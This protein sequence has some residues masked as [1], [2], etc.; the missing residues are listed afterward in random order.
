[1]NFAFPTITLLIAVPAMLLLLLIGGIAYGKYTFFYGRNFFLFLRQISGATDPPPE[2]LADSSAHE[3][4]RVSAWS[5]GPP[6]FFILIL[7]LAQYPGWLLA[8]LFFTPLAGLALMSARLIGNQAGRGEGETKSDPEWENPHY[9]R[10]CLAPFRLSGLKEA[11][12]RYAW[13]ALE[14]GG[15]VLARWILPFLLI[16]GLAAFLAPSAGSV[17]DSTG[18]APIPSGNAA[19]FAN[20]TGI[21]G[22]TYGFIWAGLALV[23]AALYF[24]SRRWPS[25][26]SAIQ[27]SFLVGCLL[28]SL[29]LWISLFADWSHS[30]AG[31]AWLWDN[32][33]N[34]TRGASHGAGGPAWWVAPA[35]T[36]AVFFAWARGGLWSLSEAAREPE[37]R[38]LPGRAL[39]GY[40]APALV[41]WGFFLPFALVFLN[42]INPASLGALTLSQV[43]VSGLIPRL[44]RFLS[45]PEILWG[46]LTGWFLLGVLFFSALAVRPVAG[47]GRH[48]QPGLVLLVLAV[49]LGLISLFPETFPAWI[50]ADKMATSE[51]SL[52]GEAWNVAWWLVVFVGGLS[53]L[54]FLPAVLF[55]A[56]SVFSRIR[57]YRQQPDNRMGA[58]RSVYLVLLSLLPKNTVSRLVGLLSQ[59]PLPRFLMIPVLRLFAH[60]YKINIEEAEL[61]LREYGS[62]NEF[63]TRSLKT[64]A[65]VI[66]EE[67][68]ILVSPVD[69]RVLEFGDIHEDSLMQ[70]KGKEFSLSELLAVDKW[71]EDFLGGKFITL[72]L[73]PQDYHRIHVPCAG[74]VEGFYYVPGKL[75]PVN[76]FGVRAVSNLF[77][78]N[79]RLITYYRTDWGKIAIIK[80]GATSVG[81]IKV[82]YAEGFA[83]NRLT[84]RRREAFQLEKPVPMKKGQE[85]GMFQ[86]GSTVIL[87]FERN[88][89]EFLDIHRGQKTMLGQPIAARR[90]D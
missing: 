8:C 11:L 35:L 7:L 39:M 70:V 28:L 87:V 77:S 27:I 61:E 78:K 79:E 25:L 84:N 43:G 2:S 74:E 13:P 4:A 24:L 42:H 29:G 85:V 64:G 3:F 10:A 33:W 88:T 17:L 16:L 1:M 82:T 69:G 68:N 62:L 53:L 57:D 26:I 32:L 6:G 66:N 30:R 75:F 52:F 90:K 22:A 23:F 60:V 54:L 44:V 47:G 58:L 19:A 48:R 51:G 21:T 12:A 76:N 50:G 59:L 89:V 40:F 63:F 56:R 15:L 46:P 18:S 36:V 83:T 34:P 67:E 41:T 81:K 49:G 20:P 37:E 5:W 72:Y 55:F 71:R 9:R 38:S 14:T 31:L 86:M 73:S 45:G 80:I 65:R